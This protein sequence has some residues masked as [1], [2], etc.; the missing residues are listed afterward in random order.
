VGTK[1]SGSIIGFLTD[2]K[3]A[4]DELFFII[5]VVISRQMAQE[6][7]SDSADLNRKLQACPSTTLG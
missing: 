6:S 7:Y 5:E 3:I 2:G 4:T 1:I